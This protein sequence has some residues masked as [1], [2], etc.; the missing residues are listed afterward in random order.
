VCG[1]V[2]FLIILSLGAFIIY[3]FVKLVDKSILS[4]PNRIMGLAFGMF[5]GAVI[6]SVVLQLM[7]PFGTPDSQARNAS[8]L[9]PIVLQ[10]GPVAYNT[11]MTVIPE[12][13]TFT[14]KVANTIEDLNGDGN[15]AR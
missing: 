1:S 11:F 6:V 12:A 5:K 14:E 10:S 2:L 9:Y 13:K 15:P 4:V 8:F 7:M 3:T